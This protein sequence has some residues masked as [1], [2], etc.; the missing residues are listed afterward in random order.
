[1][2]QKIL[3]LSLLFFLSATSVFAQTI[4]AK[5]RVVDENNDELMAVTIR[6]KSDQTKGAFSG[7]DGTFTLKVKKGE[8]L[9]FSFLGYKPVEMEASEN[10][11]VKM[12]PDTETLEEVVVV[13]YMT[14]K[15]A[16][17]SA[18]VVKVD[19]KQLANKPV[20]N[21]LDAI[22][23][24]VTG[25]QVYSSSGEPSS[26]LSFALHGQGS[27]GAGSLPLVIMDGMPVSMAVVQSMNPNDIE[28]V[29]MLKDAAATS[30]YGA[31]AANGV[32]Y[33]T[34]KRGV[35]DKRATITLRGQYGVSTLA[36]TQY[37]DNLMTG[38]ELLRYYEET[39]LYKADELTYLKETLFKGTDFQWYKYIYQ[40]APLYSASIAVSGGSGNTNYYISGGGISQKGLRMG[41]SYQKVFGRVNLN[42]SFN[43]YVRC[44]LNTSVSG[45]KSQVSPFSNSNAG[46]GGLAAMNPP[47]ISPFDPETGKEL[48]YI[49]MLEMFTPKHVIATNPGGSSS[50]IFSANGQITITPIKSVTIRSMGGIETSYGTSRNRTLPS[51]GKAYGVGSS[52]RGYGN[53]LN[54]SF[55]NT[56]KWQQGFGD[57]NVTALLGHEYIDYAD[58]NFSASGAGLLDDRLYTLNN[59]TKDYRVSEGG[60]SYA[61]LSYFTQL[62]Y[63]YKE[64]YFVDLVLRNDASSRFS[65][66]HRNGLF[67]S[68]GLLW[69]AKSEDFLR[70][71][72]WIDALDVKASYG[73]Q[74]NA[75][76]PPYAIDSYAG[77]VGQK[78]GQVSLGFISLG[79]P[80]LTWENQSKFTMGFR[81]RLWDRLEL[82]LEY[83][84]RLTSNMLFEVPQSLSTGLPITGAGYV[85]KFENVGKYLN[86]GFDLQ[87]KA[88]IIKPR[89][90]Y[91]LSCYINFS[92]NNDKVVELFEGRQEWYDPGAQQAFIVG[93]PITFVL[94][95]YKGVNTETGHPEWYLPGDDISVA[96]RDDAK[97]TDEWSIKLEQNTGIPVYTPMVGG[98]GFEANWKGFYVNAD[99]AFALGK[100]MISMDKRYY[101]NDYY[102]RDKKSNFNGSRLLFD[103]WK[104]PGDNTEF[105]SLEYVRNN[106]ESSYLDSK[107]LENSSF[108]RMKNLTIGYNVPR[109]VL[110]A[111]NFF[112]SARIYFVGRNL[113]TFTKFRGIDP[114]V[115]HNIAMGVNPNT[116]QLSLGLEVSF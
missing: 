7:A 87:L 5:G 107:M 15:V 9:I 56:I 33:I 96:T 29:Q 22:Q 40:P 20:A 48:E 18:S 116:K 39:G 1:M 62:S 57:H 85:T 104:K 17:T 108:M 67:W 101:E 115:G 34:T 93:K 94:P 69:K 47:F 95:L 63:D 37:F 70:N 8:I 25:L 83:Y 82:N 98:W 65:K 52:S 4:T 86:Y 109:R 43:D 78:K 74:G 79:N 112:T 31:R 73:T 27:L 44:G 14:R 26:R 41:S 113:L 102:I 60:L 97:V 54:L 75:S 49:P 114:E 59:V 35:A 38:P 100:H 11:M 72:S 84:N 6:A 53:A 10:M 28:S 46:G 80:N 71:V 91:G 42:T 51:Y 106:K 81:T 45:D 64:K 19:A 24:K 110:E 2:K 36:N 30:I 23:G 90:D 99:F 32:L 58:D 50:F 68:A 16:N 61:F 92:H 55:T 111:Q 103:Y 89:A 21:P 88:D 77:K 76:I 12:E 105:P 13:G 3:M 66:A